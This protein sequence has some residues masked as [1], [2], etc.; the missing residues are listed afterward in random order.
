[1]V[2]VDGRLEVANGNGNVVDFSQQHG[3]IVPFC[4]A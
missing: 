2:V 4:F 1:V 3:S